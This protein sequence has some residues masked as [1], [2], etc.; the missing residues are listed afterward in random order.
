M[1]ESA[2]EEGS[3]FRGMLSGDDEGVGGAAAAATSV[4]TTVPKKYDNP[5]AGMISNVVTSMGNYLSV[6]LNPMRE[7]I[8][9]KTM[10]ALNSTMVSEEQYNKMA[11]KKFETDKKRPPSFKEFMHTS[12]LFTTLAF[13]TVAIQTAIPVARQPTSDNSSTPKK[14]RRTWH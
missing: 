3:D 14:T 13:L 12:L 11:Q 7:F 6:D 5:R 10:A 4:K 8:V 2:T 1:L 9:E